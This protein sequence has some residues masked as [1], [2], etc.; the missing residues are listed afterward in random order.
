MTPRS[1]TWEKFEPLV[2]SYMS[3]KTVNG[4]LLK[5]SVYFRQSELGS[6]AFD[7]RAFAVSDSDDDYASECRMRQ[8]LGA[9]GHELSIER[10]WSTL[11]ARGWTAL[12]PES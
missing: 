3:Y 5:C 12:D 2:Q 7:W 9:L 6:D 10:A 4:E 8:M 1:T 11:E